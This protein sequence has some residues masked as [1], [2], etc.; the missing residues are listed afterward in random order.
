MSSLSKFMQI[1]AN[2]F[3]GLFGGFVMMILMDALSQ[4]CL[5]RQ[6]EA[7]NYMFKEEKVLNWWSIA[8]KLALEETNRDG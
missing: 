3:H 5:E 7:K 1:H 4:M 2:T 8:I 6:Y